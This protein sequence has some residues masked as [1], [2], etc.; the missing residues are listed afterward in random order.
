VTPTPLSS[1]SC[2]ASLGAYPTYLN[3]YAVSLGL[4]DSTQLTSMQKADIHNQYSTDSAFCASLNGNTSHTLENIRKLMLLDMVPDSGQYARNSGSGSMYNKYSIFSAVGGYSYTQP[5]YKNPRNEAGANNYYY[6]PFG[7]V[8]ST[9]LPATLSTLSPSDFELSFDNSWSNSLL[10]YHPEFKRLQY[11]ETNLKSSYNFIDSINQTVS[12]AFSPVNSDPYFNTIST[13]DKNTIKRY[14]DTTWQTNYSMWQLAYGDAFGCKLYP[15][16][17]NRRTCYN[18]MPKTFTTTGTLVNTGF[19]SVTLSS[20]I[21]LQAWNMYKGLYSSVRGDMVN[22]F[23]C[24]HADTSDNFH[25]N[26][27]VNDTLITQGFRIYFPYNNVQQSQNLHWASWYP[28]AAGVYPAVSLIDSVNSYGNHCDGYINAW[29]LALRNCPTLDTFFHNDSLKIEQVVASI[30]S[31]M[32]TVCKYGTDG[33]NPFGSST[34]A[35]AYSGVTF[36]SFEQ[37][38]NF[39]FDS[40]SIPRS[41][42]YCNP[43]VIEFPKPYS[44]NPVVTAQYVSGVDTCTCS[45]FTKLKA[46]I[47]AGG[48]SISSLTTINQYLISVYQD[49]ISSVLY[50][51]LQQCGGQTYLYN[52]RPDSCDCGHGMKCPCTKCDTLLTIPLA[53]PQPLP[54]YLSCGFNDSSYT[55]LNCNNFLSY[56][57]SFNTI[58]AHNPVFTGTLTDSNIIYNN[59][60]AQY[61]NFKTGLQHTWQFYADTL[62]HRGCPVGGITG[63]QLSLSVCLNAKPLNDTT[64]LIPPTSPCQQV[65]NR[66]AVKAAIIYNANEQQVIANFNASYLAKCLATVESFK[67][68]DTI[69]EYH[70]TLYYYDQAGNLVKTIPPKGINPI[71]RQTWIDSVE[72]IYKPAGNSLVPVHSYVTR[73]CYNSLNQVN[74]QKSPDAGVSKFYYDRLGRLTISQN[75]KQTGIGN[76]YSYTFY[77]SLGRITQVGQITGST[78]MSDATA[79]NDISLQSWFTTNTA[80][81][82]QITQTG[83][84][85]AYGTSP[86]YPNGILWGLTLNQQ[87]LRNR[88]SYTQVTDTAS[89]GYPAS[90]IYYSYDIHG[91]VD[92]LVQDFGSSNGKYNAMTASGNRFKK[93]VYD[94]DLISGKVNQVSY[95]AG[96]TDSYYH[97]YSYD[98]ENRLTDVVSGRDS[99]M[100]LIFPEKEAHYVYYK[101]GPLM[102]TQLGQLMVQGLD[103]AYT[104]QG[105]LKGINPTMGGTLTNGT[106]TTEA[107]PV[108]QDVYGFSLHYYKNDYRAIGYT[109]QATSVLGA[110]GNNA[111]PLYNGNIA[112]MAVNIPKLS[113]T[114]VY[115]YHYDQLNRIVAMDMYNGLSPTAGTFT[116]VNDTSY[117][118]RVSYDPNG[119]IL[120]YL[121]N[122]DLARPTMD[123]L[124]YFYKSSTNKLDKVT[125][126]AADASQANYPLYN[127]IKQGQANGN[128]QF[129]AIGNLISDASDTITNITWNVYGK[130]ASITKSGKTIKYIYDASGNR[131]MKQTITDTT[132]YV[133]DATGNVMSVYIKPAGSNT[134]VTQTEIDLYGSSRLGM[135]TQ[136]LAPDS[137]VVLA[138]GFANGTKS[139]FARG[140]KLFELNNHLGN[141][142]VTISDRRIQVDGNSDGTVDSYKA[143]IVTANDYYP[144]GMGMPARSFTAT[145]DYRYGFN[146]KEKDKNISSLTAYDYG[147]RIYNPAIG[148]FLSLDPLIGDYAMLTPYQFSSNSPIAGIDRDGLEFY[149][150]TSGAFLGHFG[151]SQMVFTADKVEEKVEVCADGTSVKWVVA[152]NSK[153]INMDHQKFQIASK[154]IMKEG[155]SNDPKEYLD[156]A[157][158]NYNEASSR[159][160]SNMYKLLKSGYSSVPKKEKTALSDKNSSV[161]ANAA[162]AGV[163]DALNGSTD[164]TGGARRW[165]GT[166]FLAW[167]LESMDCTPQAKFTQFATIKISSELYKAFLKANTDKYGL[168]ITYHQTQTDAKTGK[169]T[170]VPVQ[171]YLPAQVFT[172]PNNFDANGNFSFSYPESKG[173]QTLTATATAGQTIFWRID[174]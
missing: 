169:K 78:A 22:Q 174:K 148:K 37:A 117:K 57:T 120:S 160:N 98:A 66:A 86:Q 125:D 97:R 40:L 166:D 55:C 104:L 56:Q 146:G 88:V 164:P 170:R 94:Y 59:L 15:D 172:D 25:A 7:I 43:Y 35:P 101:H 114:K 80:R 127:D 5:F 151:T 68:T 64:G 111:A 63:T 16:T 30:T 72:K 44:K 118:E 76:V 26:I 102:R 162:R 13:A 133:R 69:K 107:F 89:D 9:V 8:D 105:W 113:A 11:A 115:N 3:N 33:A 143:D 36:T 65:R 95:Q 4:T 75:A 52:C 134:A 150:S 2:L 71:Y 50:Q 70:Y 173:K 61:V 47:T 24:L 31:K 153:Y 23:I 122:G 91:N 53:S 167:G 48:G 140:E 83:Y 77:D 12:I 14:S 6:T 103:Y 54:V 29:R 32:A 171:F 132:V 49:T 161:T 81:R 142:L 121:R 10:F 99:V 27:R 149:Y 84:D 38:V 123:N 136:H 106:D 129:D 62:S 165:D 112:V 124:S 135:A 85:S 147:F 92:T 46:E 41:D 128:Y 19:G 109:P 116:A 100:L 18:S 141:V 108:T 79:R 51:G 130:I 126:A 156:I 158:T 159:K 119:N 157:H 17:G 145:S 168:T 144:F 42:V 45:R 67:V 82:G 152:T 110:L 20:A 58:F 155:L 90:A 138:G 139:I 39:V 163:I 1:S 74:I 137:I 34:V 93:I 87:N 73:Y 154:I 96:D 131:I 28:N 21:Q 60:F